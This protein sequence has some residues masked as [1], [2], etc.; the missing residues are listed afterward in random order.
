MSDK[1]TYSFSEVIDRIVNADREELLLLSQFLM[2][3]KYSYSLFH[4]HLIKKALE[5][6]FGYLQKS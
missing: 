2:E 5:L 4:L 1:P 3:E 6:K